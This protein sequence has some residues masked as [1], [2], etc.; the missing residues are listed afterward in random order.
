MNKMTKK[1]IEEKL[2][3][4]KEE[5]KRKVQ[6]QVKRIGRKMKFNLSVVKTLGLERLNLCFEVFYVKFN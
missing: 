1:L 6:D 5:K 2:R 3:R 4:K